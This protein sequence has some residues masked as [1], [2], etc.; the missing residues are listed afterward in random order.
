MK[1]YGIYDLDNNEQCIRVGSLGEII[2]FMNITP[3]ETT[4]MLQNKLR[5]KYEVIYLFEEKE[6]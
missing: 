2:K 4:R 6:A 3:R 1:I 5:N